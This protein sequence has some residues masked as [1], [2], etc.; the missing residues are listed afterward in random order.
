MPVLCM[1]HRILLI[2][3][4]VRFSA[5]ES[6]QIF[7]FVLLKE[8]LL[9]MTKRIL[10]SIKNFPYHIMEGNGVGNHRLQHLI[11]L[12]DPREQKGGWTLKYFSDRFRQSFFHLLG[13]IQAFKLADQ[14]MGSHPV[15]WLKCGYAG[16]TKVKWGVASSNV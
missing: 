16:W 11:G 3:S 14:I 10:L 6:H 5:N 15:G 8:L 4:A 2:L 1:I 7:L 9:R 13:M 12:T